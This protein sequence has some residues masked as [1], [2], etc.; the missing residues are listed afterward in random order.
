MDEL[1]RQ[2]S[3]YTGTAINTVSLIHTVI[4][5]MLSFLLT[6][7]VAFVYRET[8]SGTSYSQS[9]VQTLIIMSVITSVIMIIIGSNIARAFSPVGALSIIRFRSAVKETR[10]VAFI[11]LA[12]AIGMACGTRFYGIAVVFTA[13]ISGI[14]LFLARYNVGAKPTSEMMLRLRV[15]KGLNHEKVFHAVFIAHLR[16]FALLTTEASAAETLELVYAI[17][18]KRNVQDQELVAAVSAIEGCGN[19]SL[20]TGLQNIHV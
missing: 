8:H 2:T 13:L 20:M 7:L 10:D 12:M 4:A 16:S 17:E 11:F 1:I 6:L 3:Q 14:I 18:L 5:V 19:V 9:Y 15:D